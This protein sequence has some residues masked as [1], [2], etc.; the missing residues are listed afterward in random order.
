MSAGL[1]YLWRNLGRRP[2]RTI[3]GAVGIFLTIGLL[4]T[5]QVGLDSV[6]VSYLDLVAL[7]VGKADLIIS[8]A[9]SDPFNPTAFNPAP[10]LEK[11]KDDP[12]LLGLSPRLVGIVQVNGNGGEQR[13]AILVG[14]DPARE[15]ELDLA[16]F[17]PEPTLDDK[18]CALSPSLAK[19]LGLTPGSPLAINAPATFHD[20]RQKIGTVLDRQLILPQQ[21][22]D[23]VVVNLATARELLGEPVRVHSLAGTF[24]NARSYYDARDLR[25]SVFHL[26]EAGA[27]VAETLGL[28]YEA[29]LP[30]AAA[31]TGFQE[32]TSPL[33]AVFGLF[34]LLALL[35]TGLLI[36]SLISVAVE[37]RIREFAILRTLGAHRGQ[38]FQ[39]VLGESLLL[40]SL[41]V[42]PGVAA[43]V[44]FAKLVVFLAGLALK[45]NGA[46]ISLELAPSTLAGTLAAGI[47]LSL[48]SALIPAIHATRWR[49][50]D[51]L[52][53]AR[54]GQIPP[55]PPAEDGARR[56][57]VMAGV[58]LSSLS[59]VV[60]FVLPGAFLSGNASLI[61]TVILSLLLALLVGFTLMMSG[62]QPIL[63]RLVL[64]VI[65]RAFGPAGDLIGRNLR[66]HGRRHATTALLFTLSVSLVIFVASIVALFSRTALALV[67]HNQGADIRIQNDNPAE[68]GDARAEIS[69]VAGVKTVC[70]ARFLRSR[71]D[72]G[73]A[74]DVVASD[75]VGLKH[76]WLVPFGVDTN[77]SSVLYT[78]GIVFQSGTPAALAELA[79]RHVNLDDKIG[80]NPA[81]AIILSQSAADFLEVRQGDTIALSFHL[82][83][84]RSEARFRIAAVASSMPGFENFRA[85]VT[86]AVGSGLLMSLDNFRAL[87]ASAP[88]EAL[89]G[90]LLARGAGDET[91]QKAAAARIRDD[92]DVRY[93]FGVQCAAEQR[94][95][96]Q[97]LYWATQIFSG[98]LLAVAVVIAVFALIASMASTVIERR[99][100]IGVL[101]AVGMRRSQLFR[102]FLGEAVVLTLSAGFAGGAIGFALA[103][104]FVAQAAALMELGV[105]FTMPYLTFAATF[106][107]SLFAGALAAYL[108][109]RRLLKLTAAEIL[110]G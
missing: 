31:I 47:L 10:V 65:G 37:E 109:T 96:A 48:G 16:G 108:P 85:R 21:L 15:R 83:S 106:V 33:R 71:T 4:T 9:G 58:V 53:P 81:P 101:K 14:I 55:P 110:R 5:I 104:C 61:G 90:L 69:G 54:R 20:T 46:G 2:A 7:K 91:V 50:V 34:S 80:T 64:A 44:L 89:L 3:L 39:L 103:W 23:Y 59:A 88:P 26:K 79:T 36:Y 18:T 87:T 19:K 12:H 68:S 52:D 100:E 86:H 51:A 25:G 40:C 94:H 6:S 92:F 67:E 29:R 41:G 98:G 49:I 75:L 43:A 45:A 32:V 76:L 74:Y 99:R 56:P 66:R 93:R 107:I 22:R 17:S 42:V 97:V 60:F 24:R 95:D 62:L 27:A 30:K 35:I 28:K 78:N 70:E 105:V 8:Q 72:L 1:L 73:L 13:F 82:G 63:E 57:M 84:E 11:L 38:V 77:I 102:L